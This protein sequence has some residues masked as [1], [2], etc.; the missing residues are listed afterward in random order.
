ME[1]L[2]QWIAVQ[3][4]E[5]VGKLGKAEDAY[6]QLGAEIQKYRIRI[7]AIDAAIGAEETTDNTTSSP[8]MAEDL[9][10]HGPFTPVKD[11]WKPILQVLGDLGGRGNR[12]KVIKLV[13]EKMKG[14]LTPADY[15]KVKTGHIRWSNRVAW[16]ASQMRTAETGYIKSGSPRGLWEITE[17]GR[18]WLNDKRN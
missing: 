6:Q 15:G 16:Q 12:T 9:D 3:R 11:Y 13:G 2:E 18:N 17:E 1:N 8:S 14:I 7:A 4:S 5:L 10:E